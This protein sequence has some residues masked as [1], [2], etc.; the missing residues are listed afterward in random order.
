MALAGRGAA[1]QAQDTQPLHRTGTGATCLRLDHA[2]GVARHAAVTEQIS[3][4]HAI[5]TSCVGMA[6]WGGR[7]DRAGQRHHPALSPLQRCAFGSGE[8]A[9]AHPH[10]VDEIPGIL[11]RLIH[12]ASFQLQAELGHQTPIRMVNGPDQFAPHLHGATIGQGGTLHTPTGPITRLHD[13]HVRTRAD[14][15]SRA[16]EPGQTSANDDDVMP[17]VSGN[18]SGRSAVS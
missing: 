7:I 1:Q 17:H 14:Q 15:V 3:H 13:H 5:Q 2:E 6:P 16:S 9:L 4:R 11:A 18:L 10:T 12:I 8:P